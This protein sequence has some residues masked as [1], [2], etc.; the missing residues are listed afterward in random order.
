MPWRKGDPNH[1]RR[2][3]GAGWGGGAKGE[4]A[5]GPAEGGGR[6]VGVQDGQGKRTVAE[7]LIEAGARETAAER[8]LAILNDPTHPKHAEMVAKVAERMDGAPTQRLR[9][10]GRVVPT[11]PM[12]VAARRMA[13]GE[14]VRAQDVRLVRVPASRLRPGAAQAEEG[15]VGQALRRPAAPDQ[16]LLLADLAAPAAVER[17]QTVTMVFE[18]PGMVLTAQ[19]RAMDAAGR[20]ATVPVM[21]LATRAVVEASVIAPGRVRVGGV[22]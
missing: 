3:T 15:V 1:P 13:P 7:L 8:W 10:A 17:G 20:G 21:N 18:V 5:K 6:P 11:V 14:I 16:P 12:L 19:G 22:R 2:G 9:V 4:G